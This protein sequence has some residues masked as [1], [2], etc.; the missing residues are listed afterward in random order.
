MSLIKVFPSILS[1]DFAKLAEEVE[2]VTHR[3][4]LSHLGREL[5][6]Y[7]FIKTMENFI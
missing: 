4:L 3:L 5:R 6:S 7:P 2:K 1:A